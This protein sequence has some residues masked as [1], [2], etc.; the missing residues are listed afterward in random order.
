MCVKL[1]FKINC[2]IYFKYLYLFNISFDLVH[3][4]ADPYVNLFT[5][6]LSTLFQSCKMLR[7]V[8]LRRCTHVDDDCIEALSLNCPQLSSLNISG[9]INVTDRGLQCLS[10]NCK[11]I[12]SLDLSRTKVSFATAYSNGHNDISHFPLGY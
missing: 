12:Q 8:Q 10:V 9:C 1:H 2:T 5:I 11:A 6:G 3:N 4:F 7:I